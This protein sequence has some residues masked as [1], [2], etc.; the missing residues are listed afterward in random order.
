[1]STSVNKQVTCW[2]SYQSRFLTGILAKE[3]K[4]SFVF[5]AE[6]NLECPI[7]DQTLPLWRATW[8]SLGAEKAR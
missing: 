7:D 8:D 3:K 4:Q 5:A 6:E 2:L 1:M